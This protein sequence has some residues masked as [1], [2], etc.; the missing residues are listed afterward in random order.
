[1]SEADAA[2]LAIFANI[3]GAATIGRLHRRLVQKQRLAIA[4][5]ASY[6]QYIQTSQI[7]FTATA[8]P[9]VSAADL[10][11]ALGH[12]IAT[13]ARDGVT[14]SEVDDAQA[15]YVAAKAYREDNHRS[16]ASTYGSELVKGLTVADVEAAHN[17]IARVT[18]A[19]INRLV[20][21]YIAK[22][23][24]VIG[25][26]LPLAVEKAARVPAPTTAK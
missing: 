24:P 23:E 5:S 26:L 19:D 16:R 17:L 9:G 4:V 11:A 7:T 3:T 8:A 12:E 1:M 20:A 25:V 22:V 13:L 6:S 14:E 2:A 15:A 18:A 21:R 10:E